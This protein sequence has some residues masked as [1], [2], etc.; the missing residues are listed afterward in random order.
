MYFDTLVSDLKPL[1][2]ILNLY[3]GNDLFD[4]IRMDDRPYYEADGKGGYGVHPPM[5]YKYTNPADSGSALQKS[6][7]LFLVRTVTR[8]FGLQGIVNRVRYLTSL[9]R[10]HG[11]GIGFTFSYIRDLAETRESSLDYPPAFAAQVLNQHL[12]FSYFPK[13][14]EESLHRIRFLLSSMRKEY[15][16]CYLVLSLIPSPVLCPDL[17]TDSILLSVLS[18]LDVTMH[19]VAAEERALYDS[20]VAIAQEEGWNI[21]NNRETMAHNC[22][23]YWMED[24][25]LS[26]EGSV[27]IGQNQAEQILPMVRASHTL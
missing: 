22:R 20:C 2:I 23:K 8:D 10:E 16:D 14:R 4:M 25:H 19:T 9:A 13:A 21:V 6:R 15:A 3:T 5:W 26:P 18:R 17:Q 24:L 7:V 27:V 1:V 12:F 11:E